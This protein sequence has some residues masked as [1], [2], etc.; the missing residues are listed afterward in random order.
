MEYRLRDP[1]LPYGTLIDHLGTDINKVLTG[2]IDTYPN[3]VRL[4]SE[5]L[6]IFSKTFTEISLTGSSSNHYLLP[7]PF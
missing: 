5:Y 3:M 4:L 2:F 1:V 7:T 6:S